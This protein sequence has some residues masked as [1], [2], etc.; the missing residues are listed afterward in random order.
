MACGLPFALL[1]GPGK[2]EVGLRIKDTSYS[3][4]LITHKCQTQDGAR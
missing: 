3:P 4:L 1:T 2:Y